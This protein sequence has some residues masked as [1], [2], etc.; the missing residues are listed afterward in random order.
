VTPHRLFFEL[1]EVEL[2]QLAANDFLWRS[3][4]LTSSL[5]ANIGPEGGGLGPT[6]P[7]LDFLHL[8]TLAFL[9]DRTVPRPRDWRRKLEIVLPVSNPNLWQAQ[10]AL[11]TEI[12][13]FL[14]NDDWSV[15][16]IAGL[17]PEPLKRE[18]PNVELVCLFSGGADSLA[19]ALTAVR[20][21]GDRTVL[22]SHSD[23]SITSH[24]QNEALRALRQ[25]AGVNP[26]SYRVMIGRADKQ[27]GSGAT[28]GKEQTSRSRS[29]IFIALAV[30]LASQGDTPVWI[31]EN[32]FMSI[33]LPL[34][35][36]RWGA[37][38]TR[39]TH[40]RLLDMIN[41]LLGRVGIKVRVSNPFEEMTKGEVFGMIASTF[42]ADAA[43]AAL[44]RT[45]SCARAFQHFGGH[46]P[47]SQCGVCLA[48]LVRRGAFASAGIADRTVYLDVGRERDLSEDR[49]ADLRAVAYRIEK[50]LDE[51]ELVAL[52]LPPRVSIPAAADLVRRGLR[53]LSLVVP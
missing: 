39:T 14:T 22:M 32:G 49:R 10:Q 18:Q 51:E 6:V 28:F 27:V 47:Q 16:M 17:V 4:G 1:S 20:A 5:R 9:V 35:P 23:W 3:R 52:R 7:A 45:R 50:G 43:A 15:S 53:E 2:R 37:L 11:V 8:A 46:P 25:L 34:S 48:C 31:P 29:L 12:L 33:N 24:A 41:T 26:R 42:G 19:G 21:H 30:A 36:E 13:G 40:P 44:S 38:S